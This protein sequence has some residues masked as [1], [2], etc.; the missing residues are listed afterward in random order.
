MFVFWSTSIFSLPNSIN[1]LN[2]NRVDILL[3]YT[4]LE[5]LC[6]SPDRCGS[7]ELEITAVT[8]RANIFQ[9]TLSIPRFS[10][11]YSS[12]LFSRR[13][14]AAKLSFFKVIFCAGSI[15]SCSLLLSIHA[16]TLFYLHFS[17]LC[18]SLP[19]GSGSFLLTVHQLRKKPI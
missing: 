13:L 1:V 9:L 16:I 12:L 18:L 17:T 14:L 2:L 5:A 3:P 8:W 15:F 10:T 19:V 4:C 11:F 6:L 7:P